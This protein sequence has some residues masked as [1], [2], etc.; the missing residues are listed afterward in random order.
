MRGINILEEDRRIFIFKGLPVDYVEFK[1]Y[2]IVSL[3]YFRA[4]VLK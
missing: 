2:I 4:Q 1:H 3:E